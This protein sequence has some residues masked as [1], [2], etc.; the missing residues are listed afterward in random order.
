MP[1]LGMVAPAVVGVVGKAVPAGKLDAGE[2]AVLL[3]TET[4]EFRAAPAKQDMP[5]PATV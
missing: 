3:Q 1:L 5:A 2:L 4:A